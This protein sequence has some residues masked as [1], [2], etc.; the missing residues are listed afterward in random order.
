MTSVRCE[1]VQIGLGIDVRVGKCKDEAG[2]TYLDVGAGI[3]PNGGLYYF[4]NDT[5]VSRDSVDVEGRLYGGLGIAG[6]ASTLRGERG[7]GLGLGATLGVRGLIP[8]G[9]SGV[10]TRRSQ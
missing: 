7:Y 3:G 1:G 4:R 9:N 8:L 6:S 10:N 2:N 5:P